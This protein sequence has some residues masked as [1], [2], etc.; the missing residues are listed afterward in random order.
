MDYN[1]S[2]ANLRQPEYGRIIQQMIDYCLTVSD[3][4]ERTLIAKTIINTMES[5]I[6][7]YKATTEMKQKLWHHL[8]IMADFK[9]DIDWEFNIAKEEKIK[10]TDSKLKYKK[11][12][13]I[14]RHYGKFAQKMVNKINSITNKEE[15]RQLIEIMGNNIK[16]LCKIQKNEVVSDDVIFE[17]MQEMSDDP[18]NI[19]KNLRLS[20]WKEPISKNRPNQQNTSKKKKNKNY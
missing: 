20:D 13:I 2:R 10:H 12:K 14:F 11:E 1:T 16:R 4:I 3:R 18:I 7:N 5:T 6:P 15:Q 8:A 9:L 17:N 19:P